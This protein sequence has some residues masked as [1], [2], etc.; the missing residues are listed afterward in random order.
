MEYRGQEP[1]RV[2]GSLHGPGYSAGEAVTRSFDLSNAR[3]DTAFYVFAIEWGEDYIEWYVD[4]TLYQRITP[5]DLPGE[6][7][8]DHPF[9]IILNLA[10]G[11]NYV[12]P[13]NANTS[14]PQTMIVDCVRVYRDA[15]S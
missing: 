5:D 1:S 15:S 13:P 4:D 10:V 6:W 2:H 14:F 11:G 3:F 8:Y 9:Y 12:G 7:V